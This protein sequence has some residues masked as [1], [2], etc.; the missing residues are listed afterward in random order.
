MAGNHTDDL[1][2]YQEACLAREPLALRLQPPARTLLRKS[3]VPHSLNTVG[4]GRESRSGSGSG[5]GG[6]GSLNSP[7][8]SNAGSPGGETNVS[9][10][11]T[12]ASTYSTSSPH[13]PFRSTS[14]T[15]VS[16]SVSDAAAGRSSSLSPSSANAISA[17]S[18]TAPPG[19]LAKS[20]L[21]GQI[22][23][24]RPS[25]KRLASH[26]LTQDTSKRA[27]LLR[28]GE[29][30]QGNTSSGAGAGTGASVPGYGVPSNTRGTGARSAGTAI[31]NVGVG[32]GMGMGMGMGIGMGLPGMSMEG[33][34]GDGRAVY[35]GDD[36]E[37]DRREVGGRVPR[38]LG[39]VGVGNWRARSLSTPS[40]I[41]R[42][43][44]NGM[45]G[46]HGEA[47]Q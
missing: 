18:A 33:L 7:D 3:I 24:P 41:Q 38:R 13:P 39:G 2:K 32:M 27:T 36:D 26:T 12:P 45:M 22:G 8:S 9:N 43:S 4:S 5:S 11:P 40:N 34:G 23:D 15:D 47:Y 21:T 37:E 30:G 44:V 20:N 31:C 29:G 6:H 17:L 14:V 19:P 46:Y 1:R 35:N 10:A 25:Y 16:T 42:P 28:G